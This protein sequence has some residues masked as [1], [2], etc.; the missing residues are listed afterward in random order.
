MVMYV[1]GDEDGRAHVRVGAL[2]GGPWCQVSEL[3]EDGNRGFVLINPDSF[4]LPLRFYLTLS[5]NALCELS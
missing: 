1:A 2:E 3:C 4:L 5:R